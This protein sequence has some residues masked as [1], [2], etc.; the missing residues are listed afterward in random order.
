[1]LVDQREDSSRHNLINYDLE[2]ETN[3]NLYKPRQSFITQFII[4]LERRPLNIMINGIVPCF[5][6]NIVIL[7]SFPFSFETQ[8]GLC[9]YFC[10]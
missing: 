3:T 5:I 9:K 10:Q 6:L 4:E 1:M 7:L 2:K 8:I